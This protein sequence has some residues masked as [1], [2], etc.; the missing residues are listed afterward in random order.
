MK[1]QEIIRFIEALELLDGKQ[2]PNTV[3]EKLNSA[4]APNAL[5]SADSAAAAVNSGGATFLGSDPDDPNVTFQR[6][7]DGSITMKVPDSYLDAWRDPV[8]LNI[9]AIIAKAEAD[10]LTIDD[11]NVVDLI[12]DNITNV[13]TVTLDE[14]RAMLV[15]AGLAKRFPRATRTQWSR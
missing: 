15:T 5:A 6:E 3:Y 10:G 4:P 11:G 2:R 7:H 9:R 8:S 13:A 12:A 1:T 14:I